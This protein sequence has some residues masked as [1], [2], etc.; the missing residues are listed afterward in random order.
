LISFPYKLFH[1]LVFSRSSALSFSCVIRDH[2]LYLGVILIWC[3]RVLTIIEGQE[4]GLSIPCPSYYIQYT[5]HYKMHSYRQNQQK[6]TMHQAYTTNNTFTY[7]LFSKPFDTNGTGNL[8]TGPGCFL[9]GGVITCTP[10]SV[11]KTAP[12][13]ST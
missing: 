12:P 8:A 1:Y 3:Y 5:V 9:V 4:I 11:S 7:N 2:I 10:A 13:A 6:E